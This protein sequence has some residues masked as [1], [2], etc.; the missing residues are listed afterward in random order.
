M[1]SLYDH[2]PGYYAAAGNAAIIE[3]DA[4]DVVHVTSHAQS[5]LFGKQNE[6]YCTFSGHIIQAFNGAIVGK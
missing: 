4:G 2:T 3:M 1:N 5:S 6:V